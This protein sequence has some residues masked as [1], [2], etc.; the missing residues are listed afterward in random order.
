MSHENQNPLGSNGPFWDFIR[1]MDSLGINHA[2]PPPPPPNGAHPPGTPHGGPPPAPPGHHSHP[3]PP[4]PGGAGIARDWENEWNYAPP[5]GDFHE[6]RWGFGGRGRHGRGPRAARNHEH[7]RHR[8]RTPST[9][10]S[11][12]SRARSHSPRPRPEGEAREEEVE[13][14]SSPRGD[15]GPQSD[16]RD[17]RGRRGCRRGGPPPFGRR[18]FHGHNPFFDPTH[19][20]PP[21]YHG[22]PPPHMRAGNPTANANAEAFVSQI[23]SH[24]FLRNLM[25]NVGSVGITMQERNNNIAR[26]ATDAAGNNDESTFTPPTDVFTTPT[27]Y[28]LHISLPGAKK[29]DIGVHYAA[30]TSI[31]TIRG[32]IYRPGNEDFLATM[33]S[34]ERSVGMFERNVVLDGQNGGEVDGDGITAKLEDGVLVVTVPRVERDWEDVKRVDIE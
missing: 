10:G 33:T 20:P 31:L 24:P 30:T 25:R 17:R 29:E 26:N 3:P 15:R 22:G 7:R 5:F 21:M 4:P 8:S 28:T 12:G 14:P 11:E 1:S 19:I 34:G 16:W 27:A 13:G 32:V 6:G 9:S 2:G 23:T 18:G